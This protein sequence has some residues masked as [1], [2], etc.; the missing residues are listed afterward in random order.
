MALSKISELRQR[1]GLTQKDLADEL[2]MTVAGFQNWEKGKNNRKS[3]ERVA[4]LCK[5]FECLPE[6]LLEVLS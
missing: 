1:K 2:G 3:I 5:V 6:D 4:K